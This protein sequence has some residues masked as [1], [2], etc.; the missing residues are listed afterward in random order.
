MTGPDSLT[1]AER[2]VTAL[3]VT[4]LT[5]RQIAQQLFIS[6]STVE[7]HL[8]HAFHKLGISSR[9]ELPPELGD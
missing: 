3:A 5:N 9:S 7:T 2:Q 6:R 4:G 8:R 1:G